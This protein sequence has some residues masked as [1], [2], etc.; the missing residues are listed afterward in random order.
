MACA[1]GSQANTFTFIN[2]SGCVYTYH[3]AGAD[4]ATPNTVFA[5]QP[6]TVPPGTTAFNQPSD[7]PGMASLP[8]T[9]YYYFVRGWVNATP[10][11]YSANVGSYPGF[12]SPVTVPALPCNSN[13][14]STVNWNGNTTGGNVVVLI[15]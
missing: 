2:L 3:V 15:F 8:A 5:S 12:T 7:L 9:V 10:T 14:G 13:A 4:P 6:V 1:F 11:S